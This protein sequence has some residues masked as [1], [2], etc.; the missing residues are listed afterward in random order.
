VPEIKIPPRLANLLQPRRDV[1]AVA[2]QI[3]ALDHH[4][5]EIDPD[6]VDEALFRR[7]SLLAFRH[8]LLHRDRE[9]DS[10]DDRAELG[11]EAVAHRLDNP[12]A[13]LGKKRIDGRGSNVLQSRESG[14]LVGLDLAR[15]PH[16]V[17]GEYGGEPPHRTFHGPLPCERAF[18]YGELH[19]PLLKGRRTALASEKQPRAADGGKLPCSL[20]ASK[21]ALRCYPKACG[22]LRFLN[23]SDGHS[24]A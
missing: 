10:V 3:V 2:E 11:D 1:D 4:V 5:A 18:P 23:G 16:H 15:I 13:I 7:G 12:P 19:K 24:V 17:G 6:A 9:R 20:E 8:A 22:C 21:D 14:T